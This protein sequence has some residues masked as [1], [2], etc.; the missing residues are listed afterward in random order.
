[1]QIGSG[2][3]Q[4][5]RLQPTAYS[6]LLD[7][8]YTSHEH[9]FEVG[10]IHMNGRLY[11]PLLRRF[12][13]ADEHIQDPYNTQ[14]YNKYGYVYNNPLMYNDPSGE[15][16]F[17]AL[18]AWLGSK[19][20]AAVVIG[21]AIGVASYTVGLAVT[22]NLHQWSLG[23]VLKSAFWGAVSGAMTFGIGNLFSVAKDGVQVATQFAKNLGELG[24]AFV[25]SGLHAVGQGVLS[26]MQGGSFE[27]AFW[28]GALG[29]L[30]ASA[31]GAIAGDFASSAG[32]TIAFGAISGGIGA[33]L[34]GGNFWEGA[35]IGGIVAGLNHVAHQEK[36]NIGPPDEDNWF[37][38][39]TNFISGGAVDDARAMLAFEATNPST[40]DRAMFHV[41]LNARDVKREFMG[42][43]M[44]ARGRGFK[45]SF[46]KGT[47]YSNKVLGQ[48]KKGDNHSFP[49]SVKTFEKYGKVSVIKGGDGIRRTMLTIPGSY[50]GKNGNFEFI[51]E[52]NGIINHRLFRPKK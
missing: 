46:F 16:I 22:G 1:M 2:G 49:E 28:S 32:G 20:L 8:G 39:F 27:Q 25:Q 12:L 29:S 21:A 48:I 24:T 44:G 43:G 33:E 47:K 35:V 37:T 5:G 17:T 7:R 34:S 3:I 6:L 14:N 51:K 9:L 10:L 42:Y 52:S 31:F 18:A 4:I 40:M 26:V 38:E 45:S 50:N 11:D 23:G 30:G 15:F 36:Q 13:N 41:G 19:F